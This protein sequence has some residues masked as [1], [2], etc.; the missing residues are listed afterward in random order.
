MMATPTSHL[1]TCFRPLFVSDQP[2]QATS[3]RSEAP[4]ECCC[5]HLHPSPRDMTPHLHLTF[6]A[7][8]GKRAAMGKRAARTPSIV[9]WFCRLPSPASVVGSLAQ[10]V[11]PIVLVAARVPHAVRYGGVQ[12]DTRHHSGLARSCGD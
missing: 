1:Q 2:S 4:C 11:C 9:G 7:L 5:S 6:L 10:G 8:K 3:S 12:S